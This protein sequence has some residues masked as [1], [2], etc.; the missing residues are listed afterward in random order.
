MRA[1]A[2][3]PTLKNRPNPD[4]VY[5]SLATAKSQIG[6]TF[7]KFEPWA[8]PVLDVA[9]ILPVGESMEVDF[10]PSWKPRGYHA[11]ISSK[12]L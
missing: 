9:G 6:K 10:G 2:F 4:K 12:P 5:E 1:P 8:Q 3:P 11:K 7:G